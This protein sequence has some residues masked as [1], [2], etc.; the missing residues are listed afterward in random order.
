MDK[1]RQARAIRRREGWSALLGR[2]SRYVVN[3]YLAPRY[4]RCKSSLTGSQIVEIDGVLVDTDAEVFSA[5]MKNRI[6]RKG[7][8]DAERRLIETHI[9]SDRP[10][11]DLGA[12]VGYTACVADSATDDATTVVAVEA[13]DALLPVI[14]RTRALNGSEFESRHAAYDPTD[15]VV[16]FRVAEDFWE[17]SRQGRGARAG[18]TV[19]VPALSVEQILDEYGIER[20]AQ[21]VVDVEGAEHDLVTAES[22]TLRERVSLLIFEYHPFTEEPIEYYRELLTENGFEFVTSQTGVYVFENAGT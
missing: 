20:P 22:D 5:T 6:R 16:E 13:N 7:Y 8:E 21:L 19:P 12:G 17:S 9:R 4:Y 3:N 18:R 1:W 11:V 14:E 10:V 15:D 2:S